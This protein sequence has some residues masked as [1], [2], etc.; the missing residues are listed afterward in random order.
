MLHCRQC[1]TDTLQDNHETFI[2][3]AHLSFD[4]ALCAL[5]KRRCMPSV[6]GED[7]SDDTGTIS[8]HFSVTQFSHSARKYSSYVATALVKSIANDTIAFYKTHFGRWS[9]DH[10]RR[11]CSR[12]HTIFRVS[13]MVTYSASFLRVEIGIDRHATR[14]SSNTTASSP[15][16]LEM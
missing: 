2:L 5:R 8:R 7:C 10:H 9:P 12:M 13:Q 4:I 6:F 14:P 16:R 3:S 1:R 11:R 15:S